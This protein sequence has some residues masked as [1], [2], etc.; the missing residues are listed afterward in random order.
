MPPP[1]L[2]L[3]NLLTSYDAKKKSPCKAQFANGILP[4][5]G[6]LYVG[7]KQAALTSFLLNGLFI[8]AAVYFYTNGNVAAGVITTSFEMGWYFGG[9]YGAGEAAKYYNERLYERQA[10]PALSY[11]KLFPV[12]MLKYGF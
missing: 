10:Y 12:L 6:Y 5:A 3:T 11:N 8:Y 9:I 1:P 4:G 7:Q 2:F